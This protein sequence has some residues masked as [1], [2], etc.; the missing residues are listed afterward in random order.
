MWILTAWQCIS[1]A[2]TVKGFKKCCI[3]SAVEGSDDGM[4]WDGS[5]EV[6][7][8]VNVRKMKALTVKMET[9]TLIDKGRQNLTCLVY[10][11]YEIN[12]TIFILSRCLML[13]GHLTFG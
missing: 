4:L 7:L 8:G 13:G 6:M 9:V 1:L 3:S 12:N 10:G 2:V 11:V 5:A